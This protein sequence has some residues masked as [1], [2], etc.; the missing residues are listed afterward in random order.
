MRH[1]K[2]NNSGNRVCNIWKL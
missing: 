2:S 1:I